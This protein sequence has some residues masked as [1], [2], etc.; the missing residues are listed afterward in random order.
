MFEYEFCK[1]CRKVYTG[2]DFRTSAFD[3]LFFVNGEKWIRA[4]SVIKGKLMLRVK[5][6]RDIRM[7]EILKG[8]AAI[9]KR[10]LVMTNAR[11]N[12]FIVNVYTFN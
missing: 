6:L 4:E 1:L 9:G 10:N 3:S 2:R 11:K 5:S 12:I 8:C 7:Y